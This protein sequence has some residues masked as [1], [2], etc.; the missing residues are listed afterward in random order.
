MSEGTLVQYTPEFVCICVTLGIHNS[1]VTACITG[2][3]MVERLQGELLPLPFALIFHGCGT[4]KVK[5]TTLVIVFSTIKKKKKHPI[6]SLYSFSNYATYYAPDVCVLIAQK[7][8][9]RHKDRNPQPTGKG[10]AKHYMI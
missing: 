4:L 8:S 3:D 9:L 5:R 6:T 1:A 7:V 10:C 2:P